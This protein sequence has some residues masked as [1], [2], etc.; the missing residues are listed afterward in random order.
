MLEN[1]ERGREGGSEGGREQRREGG[2][3]GVYCRNNGRALGLVVMT[4]G[5]TREC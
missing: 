2:G 5:R 1:V 4:V 3:E